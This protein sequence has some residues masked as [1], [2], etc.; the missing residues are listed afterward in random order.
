MLTHPM[1]DRLRSLGLTAMADALLEM[2]SEIPHGLNG[3]TFP[4]VQ[5]QRKSQHHF[6]HGMAMGAIPLAEEAGLQRFVRKTETCQRV[7]R[8]LCDQQTE[9][10]QAGRVHRSSH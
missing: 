7:V 6:P 1:A 5:L 2:R 10:I 8:A 9:G 3:G 4:P